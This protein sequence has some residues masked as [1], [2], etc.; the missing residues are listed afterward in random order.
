MSGVT[1]RVCMSGATGSYAQYI[2]GDFVRTGAESGGYAVYEKVGA[3]AY[4]IWHD[5][6]LVTLS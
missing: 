1:P 6:H 4:S 5:E 2:D 3:A